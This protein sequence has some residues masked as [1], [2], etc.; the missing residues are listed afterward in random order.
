[1]ARLPMKSAEEMD[2]DLAE[3]VGASQR[4]PLELGN[5]RIYAHRPP[6]AMALAKFMG[7]VRRERSLPSRLVELVRLRVAFHNQCRSCMAIRYAD[8]V[9]GGV[10]E[11]LVCQLESPGD[12]LELD[13]R[14]KA[15]LEFADLMSINHLAITDET[16]E[17]LRE[18]FT[19]A[20]VVELG[21]NIAV[22]IGFG[23]LSMA[24]DMV[25]ELPE[26]FRDRSGAVISPWGA[27]DPIVV[28]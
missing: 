12:S 2:A 11:D 4:T 6:L 3:L 15:A 16:I 1:M 19:D 22:F 8:A 28:R 9:A 18:H 17:T 7:T 5:M 27:G 25:D 10:T 24:W 23:R 14:E 21:M 13:A 20:E 26:E